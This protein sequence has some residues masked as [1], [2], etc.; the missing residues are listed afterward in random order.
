M[1]KIICLFL[2]LIS[3][4][5]LTACFNSPDET[6]PVDEVIELIEKLPT[7]ITLDDEQ[8]VVNVQNKY[9]ELSK[10]DQSMVTNYQK[11]VQ[12]IER[13]G[14]LKQEA[15]DKDQAQTVIDL[16]SA[17]PSITNLK[18]SDESKVVSARQAYES[19][20]AS[21]KPYVNNL[22]ILEA[23]ESRL[24]E[25]KQE[26]SDKDQAQIVIDL[27]NELPTVDE[28][29]LEDQ[30][31]VMTALNAYNMLTNSQKQYVTNYSD[32]EALIEQLNKLL[33]SKKYPVYFHLNGGFMEGLTEVSSTQK[34]LDFNVNYYSTDFFKYYLTDIFI[35]KTS[36]LDDSTYK[37]AHKVGFSYN[38]SVGA[39][40]VDQIIPVETELNSSN[41]T[42]EYFIFVYTSYNGGLDQ[43]KT[44]RV[45][46]YISFN[47]ELPAA[48]TTNLNAICT[49]YETVNDAYYMKE[50]QGIN[51]LEVPVRDG[52]VFVGWYL[53]SDLSGEKITEVS[54]TITVYA[55]WVIDKGEITTSTILNCVSDIV[56]SNTED[57]L[58]LKNDD[59]TFT[60]SS[61]DDK[62][63][64]INGNIGST[65]KIYQTHKTQKVTVSVL[66]KYNNGDQINLSKE[67]TIAPVLYNNISTTP[68]ATYF[69]TGAVTAYQSYNERYLKEKTYFSEDTKATL[70]I[71][72]YAFI[73]PQE[74][75]TVS[76]QTTAYLD[77]V[78]EL[79][80]NDVRILGCVNGVGTTTS[81]AFK[82]ITADPT[83]RKTFINNLMDLVEK[84]NLDG[85]D[86]D[87]EA[88]SSTLKPIA[89]QVN[90]LVT[91]LRAEMNLRQAEGGSPYLITMA[92]PA[93]SYGTASDRFDF[94]TLNQYVDYINIMSYDLNKSD[95]TSHL[96]PLYKS[97][98]DNGYGFGCD[99]G[100]NRLVSLGMS[101]SKLI[102]GS[103]GYGKAYKVT[104]AISATYPGLGVSGRLTQI[105]GISGSFASGTVYGSAINILIQSGNYIQYTETNS[106]GQVVGS[107]LFNSN[108]KIFITFDSRE[109]II[110]KY[111]YAAA[112]QGVGIMCWAYTEDTSDTVIN[113]ITEAKKAIYN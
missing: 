92:V 61:S 69:Y 1:K 52:Y 78:K 38:Q 76:F 18:L 98:K 15:S 13:L 65:S 62:L 34:V 82:T 29:T 77:V 106:S 32:L 83:L 50:Y 36:L 48:P 94:V 9:N 3:L 87:W 104:G 101:R 93:S 19:L 107:Y 99:Y 91:E 109:A 51:T 100:V 74:D 113:A 112:N 31:A 59:A 24:L 23:L 110:A 40:V 46:Q 10:D 90:A 35:Y 88:I 22:S 8:Q 79:K 37:Y 11:L 17:L 44:I 84:Y 27:I 67:I 28:L 4:F 103:A 14:E 75:G 16:I 30:T 80:A 72:Y 39:Y 85:L 21:S 95:I 64:C 63:Y 49:V 58:I 45:G 73:V 41:K 42:S 66:V 71:V 54:D 68:V 70:D 6:N 105:S 86:I 43:I 57:L 102:I 7:E 12:A 108:D 96:S 20:S 81:Q 47:Q 55:K 60:W 26:A 97:S 53:T 5:P 33:N 56:T 89:S 111:N 2:V 25:L